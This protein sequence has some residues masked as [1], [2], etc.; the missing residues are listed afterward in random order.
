MV[1]TVT[2]EL[3]TNAGYLATFV[4]RTPCGQAWIGMCFTD[5]M[6]VLLDRAFDHVFACENCRLS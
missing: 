2:P 5:D 6:R 4:V 3:P 1:I